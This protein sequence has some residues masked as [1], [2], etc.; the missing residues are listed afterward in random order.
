MRAGALLACLLALPA[1]APGEGGE[2]ARHVPA[3]TPHADAGPELALMGTIPIYW[4]EAE[5][6]DD[7][8]GGTAEPHWARAVLE[9]YYQLQPI[10]ALSRETLAGQRLLLLAQPRALAPAENVALDEWVRGGGKLLLFADPMLT[11]ESHFA[12]GDR[13]RPQDVILL[14]PI[15]RH[16]GLELQFVED[17]QPG[18]RVREI[19]GRAIPVNLPGHFAVRNGGAE[20][21]GCVLHGEGL[22]AACALGRGRALVLADAAM[23]DLHDPP[24]GSDTA[25]AMLTA[26]AFRARGENTGH[27]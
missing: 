4:G 14:S 6:F 8:L 3:E 2:D 25:L 19:A 10:A 13:R 12:L 5:H 15:L 27:E 9:R 23:L 24:P 18:A 22:L 1:C 11:G 17:Q 16:W 7:L 21:G 26:T 20:A